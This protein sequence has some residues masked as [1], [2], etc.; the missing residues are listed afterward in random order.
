M[1]NWLELIL[2][3]L[4]EKQQVEVATLTKIETAAD[5]EDCFGTGDNQITPD[6]F[7]E[8]AVAKGHN[9]VDLSN[10]AKRAAFFAKAVKTTNTPHQQVGIPVTT[11]RGVNYFEESEDGIE[12]SPNLK[13]TCFMKVLG[14][15]I[16]DKAVGEE[17]NV[18]VNIRCQY[19]IEQEDGSFLSNE[20]TFAHNKK[21][22]EEAKLAVNGIYRVTLSRATA[23][24]TTWLCFEP[25]A[26]A[27]SAFPKRKFN[28]QTGKFET[29]VVLRHADG[30]GVLSLEKVHGKCAPE[31]AKKI[32][33]LN[34][35]P[36]TKSTQ[37]GLA[38]LEIVKQFA[39]SNKMDLAEAM[40]LFGIS[41]SL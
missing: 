23:G 21:Y 30:D 19:Y 14:I 27:K 8:F 41:L 26:V 1:E 22:V 40:K 5:F 7:V 6:E 9:K 37:E 33:Y 32:A 29:C 10:K 34:M 17:G 13:E 25:A 39:E 16:T 38:K 36:L 28:L 11:K 35:D 24:K 3:A 31:T 2:Q 18:Q 12:V 20:I 15:D 4:A